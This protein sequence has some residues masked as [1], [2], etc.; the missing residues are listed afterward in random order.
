M[1]KN[2]TAVFITSLMKDDTARRLLLFLYSMQSPLF[3]QTLH[4]NG[5]KP[6]LSAIKKSIVPQIESLRQ[7]METITT[8]TV[9]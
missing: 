6:K 2:W 1:I 8:A 7:Y 9:Y 4:S 3:I 5:N